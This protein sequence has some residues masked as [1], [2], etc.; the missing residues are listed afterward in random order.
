MLNKL[1][2]AYF[3]P[4]W[5]SSVQTGILYLGGLHYSQTAVYEK[6]FTKVALESS[7][8]RLPP[9]RP[10]LTHR[11]DG[12]WALR[13]SVR[14]TPALMDLHAKIL[15][16]FGGQVDLLELRIPDWRWSSN[17]RMPIETKLE[18]GLA[19]SIL[20]FSTKTT[21]K[22]FLL[23]ALLAYTYIIMIPRYLFP[24]KS[25]RH[26]NVDIKQGTRLASA[27][28]NHFIAWPVS[29]QAWTLEGTNALEEIRRN[30]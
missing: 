24:E 30:L 17:F 25:G 28:C 21:S 4:G 29:M 15:D 1:R 7:A 2:A 8:I 19:H 13:L 6:T 11:R 18:K 20:R 14:E 23:D 5:R 9:G 3:Q 22:V 16:G 26:R 10:L 27:I 12:L